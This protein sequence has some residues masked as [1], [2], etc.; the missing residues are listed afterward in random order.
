MFTHVSKVDALPLHI[1]VA[2]LI[3]HNMFLKKTTKSAIKV[4]P[5]NNIIQKG[6]SA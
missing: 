4:V 6:K 3:C 1:W 2:I 5:D